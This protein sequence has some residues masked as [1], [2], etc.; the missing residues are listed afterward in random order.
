[1]ILLV[2][3]IIDYG[4]VTVLGIGNIAV[5]GTFQKV[6]H[7]DYHSTKENLISEVSQGSIL[8]TSVVNVGIL[9]L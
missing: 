1:M 3:G 6:L 2:L 5:S 9:K 8:V 7:K 4:I